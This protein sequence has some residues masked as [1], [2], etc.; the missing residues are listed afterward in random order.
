[1]EKQHQVCPGCGK[2]CDLTAPQCSIGETFAKTGALPPEGKHC[3]H[4]HDGCH[5]GPHGGGHE[6]GLHRGAGCGCDGHGWRESGRGEMSEEPLTMEDR[7]IGNLHRLAHALRHGAESRGGQGK[8]LLL[9]HKSGGLSQHELMEL[10][11]V[12]AGSLSEVLGKLEESGYIERRQN[13]TDRRRIDITLTDVGTQAA[14]AEETRV[15]ENRRGLF[16][17]LTEAEQEQLVA[18]L[19]KLSADWDVQGRDMHR[20]CGHEH[21]GTGGHCGHGHHDDGCGHKHGHGCEGHGHH[22]HKHHH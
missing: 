6:H 8:L 13:E 21:H 9:L 12:R 2:H 19:E 11:D 7:L 17:T 3:K 14:Q 1:M 15:N 10:V 16:G 18:L 20:H 22:E 4:K 5:D